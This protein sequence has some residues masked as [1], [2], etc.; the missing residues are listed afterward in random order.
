MGRDRWRRCRTA[1]STRRITRGCWPTSGS[2]DYKESEIYEVL[3][4]Y[5]GYEEPAFTDA[6]KRMPLY[7]IFEK[8][9]RMMR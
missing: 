8:Y 9:N 1:S 2:L 6:R 4:R 3:R 5:Q 7:Y